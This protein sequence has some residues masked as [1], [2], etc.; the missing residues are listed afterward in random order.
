MNTTGEKF[1]LLKFVVESDFRED[2][3]DMKFPQSTFSYEKGNPS[4]KIEK[5]RVIVWNKQR[6]ISIP[7]KNFVV[8]CCIFSEPP[9]LIIT[10]A[11]Y[12]TRIICFISEGVEKTL[13]LAQSLNTAKEYREIKQVAPFTDNI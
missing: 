11:D 9:V 10:S 2:D 1:R 8:D 7:D 4:I 6:E 12:T 13:K 3:E 5:G